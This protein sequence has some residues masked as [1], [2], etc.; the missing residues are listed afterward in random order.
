VRQSAQVIGIAAQTESLL[1]VCQLTPRVATAGWSFSG[2]RPPA[3]A[4]RGPVYCSRRPKRR[5]IRRF[6]TG[7]TEY[8]FEGRLGVADP[9]L[10]DYIAEMLVRF[11][12]IG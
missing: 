4:D 10:I 5:F 7:L 6:F 2:Q 11:R 3:D 12:A 8:T 9:P 1:L